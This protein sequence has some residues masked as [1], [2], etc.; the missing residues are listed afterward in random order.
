M[1]EA[2]PAK[3]SGTAFMTVAVSGVTKI[4][5]PTPRMKTPGSTSRQ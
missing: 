1:P 3:F 2:T 4:D 5:M